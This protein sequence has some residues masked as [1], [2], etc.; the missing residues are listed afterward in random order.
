MRKQSE[1]GARMGY[2]GKQVIHPLQVPVV[3]E[4]FLPNKQQVEWAK[5][6][7]EAF[8]SHQK[9]GKVGV[10][11]TEIVALEDIFYVLGCLFL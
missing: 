3:Q 8:Q 6:L 9:S 10:H 1:Q 7:L 2:T 4:A 5:G 11:K